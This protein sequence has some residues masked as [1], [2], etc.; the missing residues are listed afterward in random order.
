MLAKT[1]YLR[2]PRGARRTLAA[3]GGV[4]I[5]EDGRTEPIPALRLAARARSADRDREPAAA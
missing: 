3:L 1:A 2:G 4:L 5:H